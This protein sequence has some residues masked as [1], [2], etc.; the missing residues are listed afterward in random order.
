MMQVIGMYKLPVFINHE[1]L[2]ANELNMLVRAI[3]DLD[4]R[5]TALALVVGELAEAQDNP[6]PAA[7]ER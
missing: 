5:L 1:Q 4:A 7:A 3:H 6:K 2:A